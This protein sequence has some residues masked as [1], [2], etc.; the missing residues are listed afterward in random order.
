M[1]PREYHPYQPFIPPN[2]K[3]LIVGNFPIGKFSNPLR[4]DERKSQEMDFYYG[5]GT[6]KLWR[7]LGKSFDV[8]LNNIQVIKKFLKEHGFAL[9]D[10]LI[11]CRRVNG[12]ALDT[13]LYDKMYNYEL[14]EI[15]EAKGIEE[16]LFTS[17][18][19]SSEFKKHIG[20]FPDL[21]H[22]ILI[23]PS[24]TA[25]RGLVKNREYLAMKELNPEFTIEEFRL[26][27]YKQ[28]FS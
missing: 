11:S 22:T 27:K 28:V 6:N 17:K 1:E 2:A 8:E 20:R 23:S 10:I 5:G 4:F 9:A 21:K 12:S 16:L 7:L 26:M 24:P 18:H 15:I 13:A 25:I 3:K 19:V 14:K